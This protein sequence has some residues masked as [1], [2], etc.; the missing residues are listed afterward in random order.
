MVVVVVVVVAVVVVPAVATSVPVV[1]STVAVLYL[2]VMVTHLS[3]GCTK[4]TLGSDSQS[5]RPERGGSLGEVCEEK[6][7]NGG[8]NSP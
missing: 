1:V 5:K 7:E 8:K 4:S 6:E 3:R 2:V